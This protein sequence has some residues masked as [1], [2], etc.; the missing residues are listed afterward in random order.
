MKDSIYFLNMSPITMQ[1]KSAKLIQLIH[2]DSEAGAS[3]GMLR[4][5]TPGMTGSGSSNSSGLGNIGQNQVTTSPVDGT[6]IEFLDDS[7]I[8]MVPKGHGL[9]E[10]IH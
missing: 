5:E 9:F 3:N 1:G 8:A 6:T 10:Y 7:G 4:R 2:T